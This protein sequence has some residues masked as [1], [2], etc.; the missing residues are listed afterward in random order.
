MKKKKKFRS[1]DEK[2]FIDYIPKKLFDSLSEDERMNQRE[3]RRYHSAIYDTNK[4]IEDNKKQI[5][6]LKLKIKEE[7][8]K[9]KSDDYKDGYSDLM[10]FHYDK[11]SHLDRKFKFGITASWRDKS[12]R[13]Y[14][15]IKGTESDENRDKTKIAFSQRTYKGKEIQKRESL[16]VH[17]RANDR[18]LERTKRSENL[19][20]NRK[21]ISFGSPEKCRESLSKIYNEDWSKDDNEDVK[22]EVVAVISRY[23]RYKIFE[24]GWFWFI[25]NPHSRDTITEWCVGMGDE[26]YDWG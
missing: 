11:I 1:S 20:S 17:V 6:K 24:K 13:S 25:T 7:K 10:K 23:V 2:F 22:S 8:N 19:P 4:R 12:S 15:V 5:E 14:K 16:Y 18:V 3:Y 26:M 21:N 9:L